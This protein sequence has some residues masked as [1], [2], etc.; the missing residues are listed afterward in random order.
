MF[1]FSYLLSVNTR[2]FT[3]QETLCVNVEDNEKKSVQIQVGS[4]ILKTYSGN[5]CTRLKDCINMLQISR[6]L[7]L[8]PAT[9]LCY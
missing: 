6:Y 3:T 4:I 7:I 2:R 5:F 1:L 9:Y 8:I